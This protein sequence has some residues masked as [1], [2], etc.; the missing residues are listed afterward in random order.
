MTAAIRCSRWRES[1][2]VEPLGFAASSENGA[3]L[4]EFIGRYENLNKIAREQFETLFERFGADANEILSHLLL[5]E[6]IIFKLESCTCAI[7]APTHPLYLWHYAKYCEIVR[8]QKDQL[9]QLDRELV[10]EAARTL[11][12]FL[13]SIFLPSTVLGSALT[14]QFA[15]RVG[16]LLFFSD[17]SDTNTA[18]D[19][20]VPVRNLIGAQLAFEPHCRLGFRLA[21]VDPPEVGAY[22][23]MGKGGN[24]RR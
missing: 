11:P 1:L 23:T 6:T 18:N 4:L 15:G 12:N 21:L 8:N 10:A 19:G 3:T 9:D 24:G 22:L 5:L 13:S 7:L 20:I 2:A 14:L 17:R 16:P